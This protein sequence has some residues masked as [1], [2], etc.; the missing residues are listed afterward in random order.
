MSGYYKPYRKYG[1]KKVKVDG[2]NFDSTKE[3]DYYSQLKLRKRAGEIKDFLIKPR[4][5]LMPA[6]AGKKGRI[7]AINIEPDFVIKHNNGIMEFV[8]TKGV[9]KKGSFTTQTEAW[10]IKWKL[11]QY[12]YKNRDNYLFTIV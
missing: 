4:I 6:F 8:D 12:K 10:K 9:A 2:L 7:R 11:L 5:E 1:N 3:A